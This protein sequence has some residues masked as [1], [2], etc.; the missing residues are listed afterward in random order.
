[1][2]NV[3]GISVSD[4]LLRWEPWPV[5]IQGAYRA[6]DAQERD[7]QW[8]QPG[9]AVTENLQA[10]IKQ[11]G[12]VRELVYWLN[13]HIQHDRYSILEHQLLDPQRWY[14]HEYYFYIVIGCKQ[15]LQDYSFHFQNQDGSDLS[16]YHYIY[17]QGL[18]R[19]SA[20]GDSDNNSTQDQSSENFLGALQILRTEY[21]PW[22]MDDLALFMNALLRHQE[23]RLDVLLLGNES[24]WQSA[25]FIAYF[26]ALSTM[27]CNNPF[28]FMQAAFQGPSDRLKAMGMLLGTPR[29][30]YRNVGRLGKKMATNSQ[31]NVR[32]TSH[33]S[34]IVSMIPTTIRQQVGHYVRSVYFFAEHVLIGMLAAV[35]E[36]LFGSERA[37]WKLLTSLGEGQ[38]HTELYLRWKPMRHPVSITWL[39]GGGILETILVL[40]TT[41]SEHGTVFMPWLIVP[42]VIYFLHSQIVALKKRII[43]IHRYT[44]NFEQKTLALTNLLQTERDT[45]EKS[46]RRRTIELELANS[47]LQAQDDARNDFIRRI[48]HELRTPVSVVLSIL[49]G[50]QRGMYGLISGVCLERLSVAEKNI[51]MVLDG[52]NN[53][54][55]A[56]YRQNIHGETEK[57]ILSIQE[58]TELVERFRSLAELK[59]IVLAIRIAPGC[60]HILADPALLDAAVGNVIRNAI[61]YIPE[62]GSIVVSVE[63]TNEQSF[64][65]IAD[66]GPG[67]PEPDK[68]R[69]FERHV[70]LDGS[71]PGSGMGLGLYIAKEAMERQGGSIIV[72][73]TPG[74]GATFILTLPLRDDTLHQ[75]AVP[76]EPFRNQS[77]RSFTNENRPRL[78]IVED[79][80]DLSRILSDELS[81]NF[82]CIEVHSAEAALEHISKNRIPDIIL[83]DLMLPG[84]GGRAFLDIL[85][86]QAPSAKTPVVC[87]SAIADEHIRRDMLHRGA[88]EVIQ[89]PCPTREL[90]ERLL[91][92]VDQTNQTG[93][94]SALLPDR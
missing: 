26:Y 8:C 34:C 69:I 4:R 52:F 64:I 54:L 35:P 25:E 9:F 67:I 48:T 19:Y 6:P 61:S 21:P 74:G 5:D 30:I 47:R 39:I 55:S 15:L 62:G 84:M 29:N 63:T 94:S 53:L 76:A 78:L 12:S 58:I 3:W 41:L 60:V 14:S 33:Y 45:L 43:S 93:S 18:F 17:E 23:K 24:H 92:I 85:K 1:M 68:N 88:V 71:P 90:C 86:L 51:H 59:R 16:R 2:K 49:Q 83:T 82:V 37:H 27:L 46:I 73:T 44:D 32:F 10:F 57:T 89:K 91:T 42:P 13:R 56:E 65:Q 87:Y 75:N 77:I 81:Q 31:I 7:W 66:N 70:R 11:G 20:W 50:S 22:V 36:Y 80:Q 38:S 40:C 28:L 72:T 79:N